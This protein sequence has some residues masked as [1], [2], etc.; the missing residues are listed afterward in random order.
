MHLEGFEGLSD[1]LEKGKMVGM[2][3]DLELGLTSIDDL[4]SKA[5]ELPR[6]LRA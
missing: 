6:D 1:D 4:I 2:R 3:T 5:P